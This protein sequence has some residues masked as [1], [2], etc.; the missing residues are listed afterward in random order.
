VLRFL[1]LNSAVKRDEIAEKQEKFAVEL[2]EV[3]RN[4]IFCIGP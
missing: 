3:A 1:E 4:R 2:E